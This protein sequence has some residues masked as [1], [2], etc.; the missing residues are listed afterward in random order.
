MNIIRTEV[1][2]GLDTLIIVTVGN[3]TIN[4]LTAAMN[5][6]TAVM[7]TLTATQLDTIKTD[8]NMITMITIG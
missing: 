1:F 2:S 8:I 3:T 7:N 4:A 6:L 5:T